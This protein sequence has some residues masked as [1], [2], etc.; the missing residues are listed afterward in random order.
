MTD[1]VVMRGSGHRPGEDIVDSL[2]ATT[3]LALSRGDAELDDGELSNRMELTL[4]LTDIRL[5]ESVRV[6]GPL[7]GPLTGKVTSL[8][9]RVAVDDSGNLSGET[10]LTLKVYRASD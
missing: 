1:L 10:Q 8:S 7:V 2:L 4:P 3:A 5:G 6:Q 9:H